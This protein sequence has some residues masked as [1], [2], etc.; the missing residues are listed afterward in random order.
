MKPLVNANSEV[1]RTDIK[2]MRDTAR[3]I[4]RPLI[5]DD[6]SR[7]VRLIG[8]ILQLPE[9]QATELFERVK[10]DFFNRHKDLRSTVLRHYHEVAGYIP[11]STPISETK[12]MLIGSYFTM[13]YSIESAALFNPSIVPHPDQSGLSVGSLRFI[14]SLRATGEGHISSIVFR[15]GVIDNH[16]S[17]VLDMSSKYA[18]LPEV[19]RRAPEDSNYSIHFRHDQK[20]SERVIFPVLKSESK[21]IED[22]RFV[23][24][25][26]D[27]GEVTYFGTYTAYDGS[28]V[29]PQFIETKDF[30]SFNIIT[31]KG[32]AVKNKGMALFPRKINGEYAML[33]RQDGETNRI[34]FSDNLHVWEE[35]ELIQE[36]ASP[37][38]FVQIGNCG[39]PIE[40]E[41]GWLVLT[42][43]VGP[44]RKYSIGAILLDLKDP[45]KVIAH[46]DEPLV[47]PNEVEREGYVPNVVYSCGSIVHNG[48]LILPY[49]MSDIS[50]GIVTVDVAGLLNKII[51]VTR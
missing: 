44:M 38:E 6:K 7:I 3:V 35:S 20:I 31:L 28:T 39:S 51:S 4:A 5:P 47:E 40:T 14:M 21:G 45:R 17:V 33:S 8:K 27:N 43:G 24:F 48:T 16:G 36:P 29:L 15:S 19:R 50:S 49:A 10:K 22:A 18:E 46:L 13:E 11:Q 26:D 12:K 41:K 1:N 37:W 25:V 9:S 42:H 23:R 30:L 34:M 2:I 32:S